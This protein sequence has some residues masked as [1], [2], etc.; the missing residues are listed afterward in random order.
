MTDPRKQAFAPYIRRLGDTLALKDWTFDIVS[1]APSDNG[2]VSIEPIVGRKLV[3]IRLSEEFLE[4]GPGEQ[5]HSLTHELIHAHHA[6]MIEIAKQTM[7]DNA[8]S[9]F[10]LMME[11]ATDGL[12]DGIASLLPLPESERVSE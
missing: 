10:K 5:R 1:S 3:L 9:S 8:W 2:E 6:P 12:A 4:S 7:S 11:Y